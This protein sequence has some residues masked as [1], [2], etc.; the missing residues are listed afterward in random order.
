MRSI[1]VVDNVPGLAFFNRLAFTDSQVVASY[2]ARGNLGSSYV[3]LPENAEPIVVDDDFEQASC[4]GLSC[5]TAC[6][7]SCSN[8]GVQA[9]GRYNAS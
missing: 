8:C 9:M 6:A 3:Q 7:L 5:S 2:R 4:C 1:Y